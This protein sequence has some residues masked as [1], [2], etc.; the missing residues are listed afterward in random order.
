MN[1]FNI[2]PITISI[3]PFQ[4]KEVN[5]IQW[6]VLTLPRGTPTAKANCSF[7]NTNENSNIPLFTWQLDIPNS[8][9]SQWLEDTVIDDY[10]CSTDTRLV[11]V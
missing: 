6:I 8:I 7:L 5:A 1:Y 9:L 11:K 10:I 3:S 2:E 4:T